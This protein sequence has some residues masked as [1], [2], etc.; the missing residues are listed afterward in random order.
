M[1]DRIQTDRGFSLMELMFVVA[2]IGVLVAM[3]V[4]LYVSSKAQ[5]ERKACYSNQRILEGAVMTWLSTGTGRETADLAGV[6]DAAHPIVVDNIVGD[7]PTCPSAPAPADPD[8]PTVAEGAYTF[9]ADGRLE[10]CQHGGLGPHGN[11]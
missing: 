5:S 7:A 6:V 9:Q 3:A 8:N 4:P 1:G 11:F 10:P 2:V